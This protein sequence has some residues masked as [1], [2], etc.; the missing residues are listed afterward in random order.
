MFFR[1]KPSITVVLS[2]IVLGFSLS[3]SLSLSRHRRNVRS[4]V[5]T[6]HSEAITHSVS[7]ATFNLR[8]RPQ[9][10][11][12]A[13]LLRT[14]TAKSTSFNTDHLVR[15]GAPPAVDWRPGTGS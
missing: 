1:I 2:A 7:A 11:L 15:N 6:L 5:P 4:R 9:S 14:S 3:L 12:T 8:P 13:S 10:K